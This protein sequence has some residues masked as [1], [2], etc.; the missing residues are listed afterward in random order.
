[1]N[2]LAHNFWLTRAN[3]LTLCRLLAAPV[4]VLA[5]FSDVVGLALVVFILA[6]ASDFADGF[7]ARRYGEDS[8]LGRLFDHAT[9][10]IFV[11]AGTVAFAYQGILPAILPVL[12]LASFLQYALDSGISGP[13]N[14][15][16]PSLLGRGNGIAYY[17]IVAIP[18]LRDVLSLAW[19]G[20]VWVLALGWVLVASTLLS[21]ASRL[22]F[23]LRSRDQVVD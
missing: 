17:G 11:T 21:M 22:A 9:D 2:D 20:P 16:R 19:P 12:I 3:A 15:P 8:G 14:G 5:I 4:L 23:R 13:R 7:V 6:V 18:L 1:M 10:A